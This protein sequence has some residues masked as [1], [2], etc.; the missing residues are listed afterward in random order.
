ML[1]SIFCFFRR[2]RE[3]D[4]GLLNSTEKCKFLILKLKNRDALKSIENFRRARHQIDVAVKNA[5][6]QIKAQ[7][8]NMIKQMSLSESVAYTIEELYVSEGSFQA[9]FGK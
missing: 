7:S 8:E 3:V 9:I 4:F 5:L 6:L 1:L 2:M